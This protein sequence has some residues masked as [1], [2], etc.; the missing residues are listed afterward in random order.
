ME[1]LTTFT[2]AVGALV[3]Q[4]GVDDYIPAGFA[5]MLLILGTG[6]FVWGLIKGR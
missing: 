4:A 3:T 6:K 1:F 5:L 2:T